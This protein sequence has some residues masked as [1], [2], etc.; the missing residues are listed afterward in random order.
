MANEPVA[1]NPFARYEWAHPWLVREAVDFLD[2]YVK[3]WMRAFEWG[4]GGSTT[5]LASRVRRVVT[6]E[7]DPLWAHAL[8][9]H[10]IGA[11]IKNVD[12]LERA[13]D[14]PDFVEYSSAIMHEGMFDI[15]LIDGIDG[16]DGGLTGSRLACARLAVDHIK[17]GGVIV[18][19][20]AGSASNLMAANIIGG[21]CPDRR[22]IVGHAMEPPNHPRDDVTETS[23]WVC[24]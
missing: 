16:Y 4:S 5:W 15:I 13:A 14:Y 11:G 6:V 20:N 7:H 8:L 21:R 18:L 19:D 17:S 9:V 12:V 2:G 23:I 1:D 10:C 24:P 3:P 22:A